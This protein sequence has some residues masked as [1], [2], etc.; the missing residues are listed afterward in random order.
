M[1]RR[2]LA[3]SVVLSALALPLW[4]QS[5]PAPQADPPLQVPEAQV[6]PE[7]QG[8]GYPPVAVDPRAFTAPDGEFVRVAG[9]VAAGTA[10]ITELRT[11][12][13]M[14]PRLY[15]FGKPVPPDWR[16]KAQAGIDRLAPKP[17]E[18]DRGETATY[19][20]WV[21]L[22][23]YG[24]PNGPLPTARY[25]GRA[26]ALWVDPSNKNIVLLGLADGGVWKT[27]NQGSTWMPVLDGA[28]SQ[29]IGCIAVDPSNKNVIYVGTGEGNSTLMD[30][31]G[32]GIYKSNDGGAHWTLLPMPLGYARPSVNLRRIAV[33]PRDSSK[34]YAVGDGGLYYTTNAGSSWS[35][36]TCGSSSVQITGDDL[37]LD[38]P[39]GSGTT[40]L[41][42][43]SFRGEGIYRS[44]GGGAGPWTKITSAP[45]P[46]ANVGRIVLAQAPTDTKRL[47]AT[48]A[49]ADVGFSGIFKT[50]DATAPTVAWSAG[51]TTDV[52]SGQCNYDLTAVVAPDNAN[53]LLVGGVAL[54]LSADGGTS[55]ASIG[56]GYAGDPLHVD[57][58][59][60]AMP[61]ASTVYVANDGGFWVGAVNWGTPSG[62]T[63]QDRNTNLCAFQFYGFAQ[64]PTD[65][66]RF[67]G[68]TQ[69][70]G[71][72]SVLP[73]GAW[74]MAF[75][76]DGG[77]AE[78]DPS[79]PLYAYWM[80]QW[81]SLFQSSRMDVSP[82]TSYLCLMNF[83]G[84][85]CN[86]CAPDGISP[87]LVPIALDANSPNTLYTGVRKV[88]KSPNLYTSAS[89]DWTAI[90]GT[91]TS[92]S[93]Y[94]IDTVH[95]AKNNGVSGTLYAGTQDG[96]A[97]VTRDGGA[98]WADISSGL[99]AAAVTSFTTDPAD[100]R[101]VL[102]TLSG[103]GGAHVFR[104]LNAGAS[105]LDISGSLPSHPFN[106]I[107]LS[108]TDSN[109]AYAGSDF[110]VFENALVWTTSTWTSLFPNL[111]AVSVQ[112]LQFSKANGRLRAATF[113]R[114]IWELGSTGIALP[115][116]SGVSP[117]G[118]G[119]AGGTTVVIAGA[120]LSGATGV[121]FGGTAASSFTV[122]S[123][124]QITAVSPAHSSAVVD[125]Q[126]TTPQGTSA[127]SAADWFAYEGSPAVTSVSPA[128]GSMAGGDYVKIMG[129]GFVGATGVTFGGTAAT[130]FGVDGYS[131]MH[132]V[133]PAHA[134]G[135][136]DVRVTSP[137]GTSAVSG[138]D[139]F[140]YVLPPA[141]TAVSP[142]GGHTAGGTWISITGA[143]FTGAKAVSLGGTSSPSFSVNSAT[144]MTAFC[145]AHAAGTVDVRVTTPGG[146]SAITA[147]DQFVYTDLPVVQSISVDHGTVSG[148]T[149]LTVSG[150]NLEGTTGVSF[151]GTAGTFTNLTSYA[152]SAVTPARARGTV[153]MTVT[154]PFGT[155][156][157][158]PADRFTFLD[159][160]TVT[161]VSPAS[162][163]SSGGTH[164]TIT[165]TDFVD[166]VS[167]RFDQWGP[168]SY[169]VDSP[170]QISA[171]TRPTSP[172]AADVR[173]LTQLGTSPVSPAAKF[174]FL[175]APS[176]YSLSP[177]IG[178]SSGGTSVTITGSDLAGTTG[179]SFGGTAAASFSV[180]SATQVQ[181]ASPAHAAGTV[182][183]TVTTPGGSNPN[184]TSDQ[185]TFVSSPAVT[186]VSPGL[187]PTA[188]G[189]T[190]VL[191]GTSF[192][193][194][195]AVSFGG[196]AASFT[197]NSGTQI[198]AT[199]PARVPGTVHIAVTTVYGTSA[200]GVSD[201]FTYVAQPVVSGLSPTSGLD[202][203]G[204]GRNDNGE[205]L[206]RG[207]ICEF[208]RHGCG[209]LQHCLG[210]SDPVR[211]SRPRG[212]DGPYRR[213]D[214][215]R[216]ECGRSLGPVHLRR[217]TC[218]ERPEPHVRLDRGG[219]GRNDNGERLHRGHICEFC[220]HGCGLL[221]HCLGHSDPVRV[222]RPRGGDGPYRR[223]D[224]VRH[225]CGR[226]LG[227]VHLRRPTCS[228]RPEPHLR[229]N[230]GGDGGD[231]LGHGLHGGHGCEL[232]GRG[233]F[234]HG[235]LWDTDHGHES[236]S[237]A[238]DGPRYGH[239]ALWDECHGRGGSVHL[240]RP[241]CSER[242]EP[243]L[244]ANRGGD[245][246]D[247]LGHGLHGGNGC[248]LRR[249]DGF[250]HSQ[251]WDTDHGHEPGSRARDGPRYSHDAIRDE[252]DGSWRSV[253]L[254]GTA[255]RDGRQPELRAHVGGNGRRALGRCVYWSHHRQLRG[256]GSL[257]RG[258]FAN[259]DRGYDTG[260]RRG[261]GGRDRHHALRDEPGLGRGPLHLSAAPASHRPRQGGDPALQARRDGEQPSAGNQGVRRRRGV[262]AGRLEKHRED[263]AH[264]VDQDPLPQRYGEDDEVR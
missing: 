23:P 156:A 172:E 225:E 176:V 257:L 37:V 18:T 61:D 63:W 175:A 253:F 220:R 152:I 120:N 155:S 205:R 82:T 217:P 45:F 89:S 211:V 201:Q 242:P 138:G 125:V 168:A 136:V 246:G 19:P 240:R 249:H 195:T 140:A 151:G 112:Q 171:V 127:A 133:S 193:G 57:Q 52:C 189:T 25:A 10:S 251:R 5:P 11:Y 54:Y 16:L 87:F 179:V 53:H 198:T 232:R 256:H 130:S 58:H 74:A 218:G 219:D 184:T 109:H 165:G 234:F 147:A 34:V 132:A 182:H 93:G 41:A 9:K 50:S 158:S 113:G 229:A 26:S 150:Y 64:H 134:A 62:T 128:V 186:E 237:R 40:S 103:F 206:H 181:A 131:E 56:N 17:S 55:L 108:P 199:S 97:W 160:P 255:L 162:G 1:R 76:G 252:F 35:L 223:D 264:G 72:M 121:S 95:S 203:G 96:R 177:S 228:E 126:V 194:A 178:S 21:P 243:H 65:G 27:V 129:S 247:G 259:P 159:V 224:G 32:V 13:W 230:R 104:S 8:I 170:S 33:D 78:W 4:A 98:T 209:L 83:G 59:A 88:W 262:D 235:Q 14:M 149:W 44:A 245:G 146:T 60:L 190:V 185:F 144:S 141:V 39:D 208:C 166:L 248:E 239:D 196:A 6:E 118:G 7:L 84:C 94:I 192:T 261:H 227:P 105:W 167:I 124:T 154:T 100:G 164:V 70:I 231:G 79:N 107:V 38:A 80:V 250:F 207:H 263:P 116:V 153:D 137:V 142:A 29:S 254:R 258:Q 75:G 238:R 2:I 66:S 139:S 90:S 111:P 86:S 43:V 117:A 99:P 115:A 36:A 20:W 215:V 122:N 30:K 148:G 91:L 102:V 71:A 161:G 210:H 233:G 173:V 180:T 191:T 214:G 221:Q 3:L 188:G 81:G 85:H 69:D 213:D 236:G 67:L 202:R 163:P 48:V 22:G 73:G 157:T 42:F 187:G 24:L 92:N 260:S 169:T 200:A 135:P 212:G 244:R 47:Y 197:V 106:T 28:A 77:F 12:F 119:P 204:D 143:N 183:V 110:G 31:S 174:T 216:H 145:P 49:K 68:G 241:T 46:S 15:P 222:S 51:S 123:A 226:S 101:R 114:G